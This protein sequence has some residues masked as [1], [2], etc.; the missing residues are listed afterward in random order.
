M[1]A[2]P[3]PQ[4]SITMRI[5]YPHE[6]GWIARIA[7]A[8]AQ[9][10][11]V[12]LAIDLV[13][14]HGGRSLRD[15]T[16]ECSST[17]HANAI[18]EAVRAIDGVE[19]ESV[20]D[21]TFLVHLG[22]KL[23]VVAK[24]PIK[25]RADL[26]MVYTPGVARVCLA[27]RDDPR[28]A[29][30]LTVRSN[31]VAVVSD[32]SAVLGLG[33]IGPVAA[34]P[35]MEG[36]AALFKEFGGVNAFPL[37][38][39]ARDVDD[40]VRFCEQIAPTFGGINLEDI[41][42]PRC[43]EIE[44]RLR[45]SLDIPVMHDDQHGTAVVM[46]AG[47]INALRVVGKEPA[48]VRVVVSGAGAAGVACARM[49][50]DFGV[51]DVIVCD[52]RGAI[53]RGRTDGMNDAKRWLAEHTNA[54]GRTGSIHD[55]IAGADVFVGVSRPGVI[56]RADV[57]AMADSPIVFAMANPEPEVLPEEIRD[58]AAVI[59]TGRSDYP[60]QINNVLAFP[61]IFRG[62]LDARARAINDEM[63]RAAA[64]AIADAVAPEERSA[65]TIVPS[66][67]NR[68]VGPRVAAAVARAARKTGVA[69]RIP[70]GL[71]LVPK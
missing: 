25:T 61:G 46:L 47:L 10:G 55:V 14:I 5:S 59:A 30:N 56:G 63:I 42:A 65:E 1:T 36:K 37:C 22:G 4:Y 26:S 28:A 21:N 49:L 50:V 17:E 68:S 48:A 11:G 32:G 38:V 23:E 60:N 9:R 51:G 52:S 58:I 2:R 69:R 33:D 39:A 44:R 67:F 54:E 7:D 34:L 24:T 70:K 62:A 35:V 45:E 6:P 3:S 16:I 18:V 8:I 13:H 15:Y 12:I 66:V 57:E 29:F 27:I 40:V 71:R 64:H 53:H 41:S 19:I 31:T 20:S 43:F